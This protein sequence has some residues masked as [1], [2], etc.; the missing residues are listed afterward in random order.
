MKDILRSDYAIHVR[1]LIHYKGL[2]GYKDDQ[3]LY[4]IIPSKNKETIYME[5]AALA[6]YLFENG[7]DHIALPI[8]AVNG[9]WFRMINDDSC[10]VVKVEQLRNHSSISHGMRLAQFHQLS[11]S[12]NFEPQEISSYGQW[13]DLWINKLT[14]FEN[15]LSEE[16]AYHSN[17][18]YRLVMDIFPYIIGISENAIQYMQECEVETRYHMHDQGT[19]CFQ[20][21][22]NNLQDSIIW[23]NDLVYDHP[24]R[25]IAEFIRYQ[26]LWNNNLNGHQEIISFMNDYQSIRPLSVFSWR[27]LYARLTFPIHLYDCIERGFLNHQYE[28]RYDELNDLLTRQEKY[29]EE[30]AIIFDTLQVDYKSL[31][32]PVLH[33]LKR[34]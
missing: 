15:K 9:E 26:L 6:Y 3:Y 31:H 18:Y 20:R 11:S 22:K 2:E 28:K 16:A 24:T 30:L 32:I 12:Y 25:D 19:I 13:K 8:P 27:L 33:W 29:E 5:Q 1:D 21:Y 10:M 14:A 34:G 4:F 17:A 7:Y 23:I